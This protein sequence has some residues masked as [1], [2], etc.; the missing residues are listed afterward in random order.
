[1]MDK[2][3]DPSGIV[4]W[5]ATFVVI[6][7]ITAITAC[8]APKPKLAPGEEAV[9]K[10]RSSSEGLI[11]LSGGEIDSL[12][13]GESFKAVSGDRTWVFGNN[14]VIDIKATDGSWEILGEEWKLDGDLLCQSLGEVYFHCVPVYAV[15]GVYRFGNVNSTQLEPWGMIPSAQR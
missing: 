1:M 8:G 11:P 12:F 13:R 7:T 6:S 15:D 2:L 5:L 14:G 4:N 3:N 9:F 10:M